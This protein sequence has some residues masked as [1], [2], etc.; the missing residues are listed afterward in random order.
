MA[1]GA[2][3]ARD[4]QSLGNSTP[5]CGPD[6]RSRLS[7]NYLFPSAFKRL[8]ENDTC[9]QL[10]TIVSRSEKHGGGGAGGRVALGRTCPGPGPAHSVTLDTSPPLQ[11]QFPSDFTMNG[12]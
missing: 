10:V 6:L 4:G 3:T 2:V 9:L 12:L 7:P 5:K 1:V 11:P 8:L